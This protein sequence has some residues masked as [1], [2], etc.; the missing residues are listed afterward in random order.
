MWLLRIHARIRKVLSEVIIMLV[1]GFKCH[2]KGVING[3]LAK[4][5]LNGV[6]LGDKDFG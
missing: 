1:R 4:H 3:P 5:H 2:Y 6:L